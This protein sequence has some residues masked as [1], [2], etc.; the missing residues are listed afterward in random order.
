M[1]INSV[2]EVSNMPRGDATGPDG[3][4][5]KTGRGLGKCGKGTRNNPSQGSQGGMG[6]GRGGGRGQGQSRGGGRGQGQ[7]GGK[8]QGRGNR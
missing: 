4:G 2:K 5:P 3:Q 1:K 6:S 7:G 8:G